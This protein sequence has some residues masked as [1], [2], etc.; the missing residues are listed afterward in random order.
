MWNKYSDNGLSEVKF[1][2]CEVDP[3]IYYRGNTIL[4][5]YVD[6]CILISPQNEDIAVAIKDQQALK[7]NFTIKDEG[8]EG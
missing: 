6:G 3:C 5:V 4:S 7:R 2:P 1:V 8:E